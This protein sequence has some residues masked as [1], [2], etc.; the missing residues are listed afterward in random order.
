VEEAPIIPL[1][2]GLA[3]RAV[4]PYVKDIYFQPLLSFVHLRT[5]K[6]AEH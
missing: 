4:K 5:V 2:R 3:A 6:I 1:Y